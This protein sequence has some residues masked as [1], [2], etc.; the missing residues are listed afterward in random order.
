MSHTNQRFTQYREQTS[1]YDSDSDLEALNEELQEQ[2]DNDSEDENG[3][4]N[5]HLPI[6]NSRSRLPTRLKSRPNAIP[7]FINLGIKQGIIAWRKGRAQKEYL[8]Q[9]SVP[10]TYHIVHI[11]LQEEY[12][13][14]KMLEDIAHRQPQ[15][16][17]TLTIGSEGRR[18]D[19]MEIMDMA[20]PGTPEILFKPDLGLAWCIQVVQNKCARK[21]QWMVMRTLLENIYLRVKWV[22][23]SCTWEAAYEFS[24]Q[25]WSLQDF[26]SYAQTFQQDI[27]NRWSRMNKYT[28]VETLEEGLQG[29]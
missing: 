25:Y 21:D 27:Q 4:E 23:G 14:E 6:K 3:V 28:S 29:F 5:R 11:L 10:K 2:D 17:K 15:N 7:D 18:D 24:T 8:I 12:L 26:L 13:N 1:N 9:L 22:N 16:I 20:W 19:V